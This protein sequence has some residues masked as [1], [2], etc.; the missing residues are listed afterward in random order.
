MNFTGTM[1]RR[2]TVRIPQGGSKHDSGS[3]RKS[4]ADCRSGVTQE[5]F[6]YLSLEA[7]D[8]EGVSTPDLS[9]RTSLVGPP[10]GF[11]H[12]H[13]S[14]RM[15]RPNQQE[16]F[17]RNLAAAFLASEWTAKSLR[18]FARLAIGKSLRWMTTL[19]NRVLKEFPTK[20]DFERMLD[21]LNTD[22]RLRL[23]CLAKSL[24][25]CTIFV[26][27]R[28][29]TAPPAAAGVVDLPQLAT[30]G[31]LAEWLGI[32]SGKM[33]WYADTAGRNRKHPAGPLRTYRYRW[34]AKPGGLARLLEIPN[35]KLKQL[36]RKI[37]AEILDRIPLHPAAHG[38]RP[39]HSIV[40]NASVHCGKR[41]VVRFDLA[42][43][44][45]SVSAT[46]VYRTFRT[47]GYP[48]RVARLLTGFCTTSIPRDVWQCRPN[49]SAD[50]SDHAVGQRFAS[51]HLPQGAPTS[52]ALA[53]LAAFPLDR[54]LAKL[55]ASMD[56]DYTRYADDL[57]F[58][59]GDELARGVKRLIAL[60]AVIV[61]SEGFKLNSRKTRIMPRSARQRVTGVV[62]N[63][64][65]N[66]SRV[67]YDRLKAILTN[68]IR[69]GPTSQNRESHPE[70]R[71]HLSGR[72]AHF[73]AINA[74]RGR[75][76]WIRFD[77]IAW[78]AKPIAEGETPLIPSLR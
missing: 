7:H 49:P 1:L 62:V 33:L 18:H 17:L 3:I 56:A 45:P 30:E 22:V 52:P 70:F 2:R 71:A 44:F 31:A 20:P 41:V 29:M 68:C 15:P 54:R 26:P 58:S 36:Q 39:G 23:A 19:V 25:V 53:N 61:H 8:T 75:K 66:V 21:F 43:F 37:L 55:A 24:P 78:P 73:A 27:P 4:G 28:V 35:V 12:D 76:L 48:E 64:K 14:D 40:T 60:V 32:A 63:V 74:V 67:E 11:C 51:R 57:T 69:H 38:F 65:P 42:D 46:R 5:A 9:R 59:S 72:I 16:R 47:F 77:Q 34:V 10:C 50:G 6:C 13:G